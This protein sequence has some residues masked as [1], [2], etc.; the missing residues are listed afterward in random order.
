MRCPTCDRNT[1]SPQTGCR[2]CRV[3]E[4]VTK[5][6]NI[7]ASVTDETHEYAVVTPSVTETAHHC[8]TCSCA[9]AMTGAERQKKWRKKN[10]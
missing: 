10:A 5:P 6:E 1:Y 8:R 4:D 9:P 2:F 3:T 7:T